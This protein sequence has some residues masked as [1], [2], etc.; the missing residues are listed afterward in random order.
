MS[1]WRVHWRLILAAAVTCIG[2]VGLLILF[3]LRKK[4]EADGLRTQLALMNTT[5]AVAGLEAD[6]KARQVELMK[7]AEV[8]AALDAQILSA[9]RQTVSVVESVKG[10]S[11]EDVAKRFKELGY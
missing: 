8:A 6:K 1:W 11:D 7:N 3:M 9:K 5:M 10:L 2:A 4:R